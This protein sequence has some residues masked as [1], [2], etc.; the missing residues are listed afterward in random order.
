MFNKFINI[1]WLNS[2][3]L[4]YSNVNT[5]QFIINTKPWIRVYGVNLPFFPLQGYS[6]C[7][8]DSCSFSEGNSFCTAH[9]PFHNA[10][11]FCGQTRIT[12]I[13]NWNFQEKI[14]WTSIWQ[15][16]KMTLSNSWR[17]KHKYTHMRIHSWDL[18]WQLTE[19]RKLKHDNHEKL[20]NCREC[21]KNSKLNQKTNATYIDY[22]HIHMYVHTLIIYLRTNS[23]NTKRRNWKRQ[24]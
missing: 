14:Q 20:W 5:W 2:E 13:A 7:L 1:L 9:F 21:C 3:F 6:N 19:E 15:T 23:R 10:S 8:T 17:T 16:Q 4:T 11:N 12:E 22:T 24:T 18:A